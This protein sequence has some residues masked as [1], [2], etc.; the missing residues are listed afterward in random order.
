M[1]EEYFPEDEIEKAKHIFQEFHGKILVSNDASDTDFLLLVLYMLANKNKNHGVRYDETKTFFTEAGRKEDNFRK[2]V[3]A[4][5][6][7]DFL[8]KDSTGTLSLSFA[9]LQRVKHVLESWP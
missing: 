9:G 3:Y 5:M 1:I 4:L 7:S 8:T 6:K 2:L